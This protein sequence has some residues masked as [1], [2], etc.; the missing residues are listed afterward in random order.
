VLKDDITPNE[1]AFIEAHKLELPELETIMVHRRLYPKNGFAAHLI[2]YV[3]EV[4]E[5]MLNQ[6]QYE[7]YEPGMIVGKSGVE[8]FY[9]DMLM[10]KEGQRRIE[11]DS[12]GR[13][14]RRLSDTPAVPGKP[15]KLSI[16]LDV[17]IAAERAIADKNGSVLA[18]DPH[19]G[20]ILAMVS[21]PTFDPNA[22]SV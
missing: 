13:E 3:G 8:K 21:R 18:M 6:P 19:T 20:E 9:N 11:V 7:L 14:L 16:D 1:L 22:F 17:Q 12:R 10:G 4:S 2:G 15:L 5:D